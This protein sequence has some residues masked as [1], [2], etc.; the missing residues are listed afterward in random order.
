MLDA[1]PGGL[2][3]SC[4]TPRDPHATLR[5]AMRLS[6]LRQRLRD[7]GA[8]PCHEGPVLRAWLRG[9]PLDT[10]R[11]RAKD[12]LRLDCRLCAGT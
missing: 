6:Q 4:L 2:N 5:P 10:Q 1:K 8:A 3:T 12:L 11:R 7:L 9:A